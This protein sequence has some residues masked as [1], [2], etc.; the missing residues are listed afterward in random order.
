MKG[1]EDDR[2]P[3]VVV[4]DEVGGEIEVIAVQGEAE[5]VAVADRLDREGR[6]ERVLLQP[7]RR[8]TFPLNPCRN[9]IQPP[10]T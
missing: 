10:E 4:H 8:G 7:A 2:L 5:E 6:H 9:D 3:A 1:A